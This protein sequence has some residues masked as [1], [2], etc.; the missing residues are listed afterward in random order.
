MESVDER[1]KAG[2][3]TEQFVDSEYPHHSHQPDNLA[4]LPNYL[5]ILQL[6]QHQ[7]QVE[8]DQGDKVNWA[9]YNKKRDN[10]Q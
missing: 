4:C 7:G 10:I 3:V 9:D 1:L 2:K 5:I 8:R 6:L